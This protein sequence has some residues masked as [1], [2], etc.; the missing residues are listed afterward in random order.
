MLRIMRDSAT[1][2]QQVDTAI[3]QFLIL[4]VRVGMTFAETATRAQSTDECL[5]NRQLA[6]RAYDTGVRWRARARFTQED[7]RVYGRKLQEL[8][9]ALNR[10]GD[11]IQDSY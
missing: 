1:V 2:W 5:H 4:E 8:R 10:L 9:L 7:T 11:P 3:Q 6:R